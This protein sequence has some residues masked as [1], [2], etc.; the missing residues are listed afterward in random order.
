MGTK[1]DNSILLEYSNLQIPSSQVVLVYTEWNIDIISEL[2]K[3]AK[4][5][6]SQFPQI[7]I[8]EIQVP[9]AIEIPFAICQYH[10]TKGADAYIALGCVIQGETPHFD[11]VCK[12]VIEGI[13]QLN[14]SINSPIIFGVL[15]VHNDEQAWDRL[16]GKHGHKGEESAIA[17]LKMI[18]LKNSLKP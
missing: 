4:K 1:Q 18:S 16:G 17:S 13:T 14:L 3:G 10:Q 7:T 6:L 9:G 5:V 8:H 12:S 11:Y 15:T 2:L